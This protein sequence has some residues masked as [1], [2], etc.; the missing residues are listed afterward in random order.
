MNA[1]IKTLR[2][3][4]KFQIFASSRRKYLIS[5]LHSVSNLDAGNF[6]NQKQSSHFLNVNEILN[7]SRIFFNK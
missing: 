7:K 2:T 4:K 1:L 3:G 6:W 5:Y